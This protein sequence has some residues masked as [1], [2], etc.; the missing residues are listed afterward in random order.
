MA[1][2]Y[3]SRF[4]VLVFLVLL[5]IASLSAVSFAQSTTG[6]VSGQFYLKG[7]YVGAYSYSSLPPGY[8]TV[9]KCVSDYGKPT[10]LA[11]VVRV[12][13]RRTTPY[14]VTAVS[15]T[16]SQIGAQGIY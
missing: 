3:Q 7:R 14:N 9:W 1:K 2:S 16:C 12:Y 15:G 10:R 11:R 5:M 8:Y 4:M 13:E 6:G